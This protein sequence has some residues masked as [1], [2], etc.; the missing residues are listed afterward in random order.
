MVDKHISGEAADAG[1][2]YHFSN[3][4]DCSWFE[5]AREI[6]DI[7]GNARTGLSRTTSDEF[8]RPAKRPRNSVLD[9]SRY[10]GFTGKEPRLWRDALREY[11]RAKKENL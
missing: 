5:F 6:V 4:G 9:T 7:W 3:G 2:I 1:G 10:T 11:L 8:K